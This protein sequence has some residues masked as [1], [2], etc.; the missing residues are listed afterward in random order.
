MNAEQFTQNL[1]FVLNQTNFLWPGTSV[2][3]LGRAH[4]TSDTPT[5]NSLDQVAPSVLI[6]PERSAAHKERSADLEEEGRWTVT[7]YVLNATD[8]AGGAA[9]VGGN[10]VNQP[11]SQ[12]AGLLE[13]EPLLRAQI[14]NAFVDAKGRPRIIAG[15]AVVKEAIGGLLTA[16]SYEVLVSRFSVQPT[17]SNVTKLLGGT[18][19]LT[20]HGKLTWSPP[21]PRWDLVNLQV[22]RADFGLPP[23][24]TPANGTVLTSTLSPTATGYTD[25]GG[26][27][28][29]AYSVFAVFDSTTDPWTGN[30]NPSA[31]ILQYSGYGLAGSSFVYTPASVTL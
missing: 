21:A 19:P 18:I 28:G 1:V 29:Y 27:S 2:P 7:L 12:G 15:P 3:I 24:A 6:R 17:Y 10:R 30:R 23:P 16:R 11:S 9:V 13:I 31:A 8:Q 20:G 26:G 22:N 4:V 25:S 5:F 14:L